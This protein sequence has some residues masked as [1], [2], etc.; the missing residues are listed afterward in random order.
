MGNVK[1]D[2]V[3]GGARLLSKLAVEARSQ[4]GT[5][6]KRVTQGAVKDFLSYYGDSGS[7]DKALNSAFVYAQKKTGDKAPS[8]TDFNKALS[9]AVKGA[10]KGDVNGSKDLSP[11]EQKALAKTWQNLVSFSKDY[12]GM[13]VQQ[14]MD[15]NN[16]P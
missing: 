12:K 11:S 14:V 4:E 6:A 15:Q 5:K 13:S 1:L 3:R 9:D 16:P 8:L 2:T 10:A 7:L